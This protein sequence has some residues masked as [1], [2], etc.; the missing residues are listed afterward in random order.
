MFLWPLKRIGCLR[1][2]LFCIG[3]I[4]VYALLHAQT[5]PSLEKRVVKPANTAP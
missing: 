5:N 1:I 2:V 3:L 4:A